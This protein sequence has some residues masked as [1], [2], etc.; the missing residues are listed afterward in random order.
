MLIIS[1]TAMMS[2][3]QKIDVATAASALGPMRVPTQKASTDAKSVMSSVDA[4]AGIA[5]RATVFGNAS[6]TRCAA[7]GRSGTATGAMPSCGSNGSAAARVSDGR[8]GSFGSC[9][10][11]E[12]TSELQSQSN[13]V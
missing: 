3:I 12:H 10:S 7:A 8:A 6:L 11:E 1:A 9:R 2:Q 5:S 4:T 13:L